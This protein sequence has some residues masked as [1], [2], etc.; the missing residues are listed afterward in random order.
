MKK[1]PIKHNWKSLSD[2]N[3][4][5]DSWD[6]GVLLLLCALLCVQVQR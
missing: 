3:K 5:A 2:H 4:E 1:K 6:S